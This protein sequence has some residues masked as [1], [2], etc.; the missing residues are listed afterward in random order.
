MTL[1]LT[2]EQLIKA[3]LDTFSSEEYKVCR[4]CNLLYVP[5]STDDVSVSVC[6]RCKNP[7]VTE[8]TDFMALK[9][10]AELNK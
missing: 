10:L 7:K 6:L 1:K 5:L 3:A 4:F 9:N 2:R 8:A